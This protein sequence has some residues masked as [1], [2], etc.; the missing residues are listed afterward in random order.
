MGTSCSAV[1]RGVVGGVPVAAKVP[2]RTDRAAAVRIAAGCD[3]VDDDAG[4]DRGATSQCGDLVG[5]A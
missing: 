5:L 3:L 4:P 1:E 2:Q